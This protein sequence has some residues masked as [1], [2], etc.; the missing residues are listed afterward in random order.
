MSPNCRGVVRVKV[1]KI[2]NYENRKIKHG[3]HQKRLKQKRNEKHYGWERW[4]R[5][6][7]AR[8]RLGRLG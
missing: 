1:N 8:W 2:L 7:L 5:L 4:K 3:R 6:L